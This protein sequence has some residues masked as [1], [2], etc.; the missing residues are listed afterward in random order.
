MWFSTGQQQRTTWPLYGLSPRWGGEENGKGK[1]KAN[2]VGWVKDGLTEQQRKLI[3]TIEYT[4]QF[5]A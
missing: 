5:T 3:R 4:E 1:K 2:L